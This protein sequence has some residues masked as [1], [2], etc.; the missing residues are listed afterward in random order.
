MYSDNPKSKRV[1]FRCPDGTANP[2]LAFSALM[3]AGLDGIINK[4]EPGEPIDKDIYHLSD[5]EKKAIKQ[6]PESL[7]ISMHNLEKDNEYLKQGGAFTDELIS[8]WIDYKTNK[9]IK[10]VQLRP[11]PYEFHLYYEV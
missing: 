7:E 2:Y 3:L 1:E 4:I 10:E 9:E 6:A 5:S 8:T 11:H